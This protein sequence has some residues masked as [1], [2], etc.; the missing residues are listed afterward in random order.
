MP[1]APPRRGDR[2]AVLLGV[3]A[4]AVA[5][6]EVDAEVLDRLALELLARTRA[7]TARAS[8]SGPEPDRARE[9]RGDRARLLERAQRGAPSLAATSA[10]NRCAPPYTVWTGWRSARSPG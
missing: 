8:A 1:R 9:R 6:L 4:V 2:V 10:E 5:V 3:G 7:W